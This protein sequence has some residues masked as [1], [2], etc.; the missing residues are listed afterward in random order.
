MSSR[1]VNPTPADIDILEKHQL[2]SGFTRAEIIKALSA[3]GAHVRR[4]GKGSVVVREGASADWLVI[5]LSG[6]LSV[7]ELIARDERHLVRPVMAG[8]LFGG[9]LVTSNCKCYP[10]LAVA[11]EE[12]RT[13]FLS[14]PRIQSSGTDRRYA[15]LFRNLYSIVSEDVLRCWRKMSIMAC[16]KA[17]DRVKLLMNWVA[18]KTGQSE[19]DVPFNTTEELAQFLAVSRTA[20]SLAINRL[21]RRGE[22]AHPARRR[23]AIHAPK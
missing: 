14:I 19:F 13:V 18:S 4:F 2:F 12:T 11:V 20:L 23:F 7:Y 5:V 21:V 3:F 17:E 10:G 22:I 15:V 1:P 9:T 6:K 8:Q 16:T